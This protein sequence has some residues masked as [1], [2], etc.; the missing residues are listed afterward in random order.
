M[1][2]I[3]LTILLFSLALIVFGC[4]SDKQNASSLSNERIAELRKE[5]PLSEG[6]PSLAQTVDVPFEQILEMSDSVI[7]AEV[8]KQNPNFKSTLTAKPGT[9]EGDAAEKDKARGIEPYKP[10]FV[11]YQVKVDE[12]IVGED[13]EE[14]TNLFYNAD[15]VGTEPDLKPG[16]K[17]VASVKKGTA[18]EQQGSY[19]FTR[20]A[21][22]YV[23]DEDFVLSAYQ[24]ESDEMRSFT[25]QT[26]G[27]TL[28]NLIDQV[29]E[30]WNK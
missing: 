24:G 15:F 9:P 16:M 18:P 19:S 10:T 7:I 11:S 13:V 14:T 30:L 8:I 28:N 29:K 3:T 22:Y 1:K 4:S 6:N 17:I 5:Y 21:T 26:D 27:K 2:R 20:Y 12:V 25:E 23:V